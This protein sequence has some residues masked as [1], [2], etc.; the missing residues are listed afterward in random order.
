MSPK[1]ILWID[2]SVE[3]VQNGIEILREHGMECDGAQDNEMAV[4]HLERKTYDIIIT[5]IIRPVNL[6]DDTI[7]PMAGVVFFEKYIRKKHPTTPVLFFTA[8][9]NH[10]I[11]QHIQ[12]LGNTSILTKPAWGEEILN[13]IETLIADSREDLYECKQHDESKTDIIRVDFASI[14]REILEYLSRHTEAIHNL[15]PRRFEK[16]VAKLFE[17]LGY[18]VT[19]TPEAKDGGADIYV[20]ERND[21]GELLY[22][23]ECKKYSENRPVGVSY[24]R[25]LYGVKNVMNASAGILVTSSYFT[26]PAK[27]FQQSRRFELTL[28]DYDS[29]KSWLT[30]YKM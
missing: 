2:D 11:Y 16:L 18:D 29:I 1:R 14:N 15:T 9:S 23:V 7:D 5:D 20:V 30:R 28:R 13:A 27:A 21:L 22:V 25:S 8:R 12:T 19:L 26:A 6:R 3:H 4:H 17:D 24:V 10:E